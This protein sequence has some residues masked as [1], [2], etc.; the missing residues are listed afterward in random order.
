MLFQL[1]TFL[2]FLWRSKNAHGIQSPFVYQLY[3]NGLN[4]DSVETKVLINPIND[5]KNSL[6]SNKNIIVV[7]DFGAGSRIFKSNKRKISKIAKTA[8][9]SN[10]NGRILFNLIRY[11][12]PKSILEIGTSLG[13]S[14]AYM[15]NAAPKSRIYTL[16]GCRETAAMAKCQFIKFDLHNICLIE[17][18]FDNTLPKVLE[19]NQFNLI[20]FDGNHQ[21]E[22]TLNYFDLCLKSATENSVFIFD[23]IHW[24]PE[25]EE[26]WEKIKENPRITISIDTFQWGLVFFRKEQA[27]QD[28]TLRV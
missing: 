5:Y 10:K 1:F 15:A 4:K 13:I 6:Y 16:E 28:F 18:N 9:I 2:R 26:A 17:G 22:P 11:L 25:M 21:K 23:D 19:N 14:T 3:R 7:S 24:N 20:F 27:K 8:G 12:N